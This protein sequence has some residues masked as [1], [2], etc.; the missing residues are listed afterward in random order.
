VLR[1]LPPEGGRR[2]V[3]A[4]CSCGGCWRGQKTH[5]ASGATSSCGCLFRDTRRL[6]RLR[7]G[8]AADGQV[9]QLNRAWQN[10]KSRCYRNSPINR[11]YKARGIKVCTQW[12]DD[13]EAFAAHIGSP[14]SP[15]HS[16]D[17][18]DN[19]KDY[20]PG[21]V[22]WATR[23][24]QGNNRITNV[25]LTAFGV[26]RTVAQ[27]GDFLGVGRKILSDRLKRGWPIEAALTQPLHTRKPK[28]KEKTILEL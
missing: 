7:H 12:L 4:A 6:C 19:N 15:A 1:V 22:H 26:T 5:L 20:E 3:E 17:R 27:W 21:N 8:H 13:F 16:V 18:L 28:E 25:W 10:M 2:Y 23:K 24:E 9:S 14:P 11:Q